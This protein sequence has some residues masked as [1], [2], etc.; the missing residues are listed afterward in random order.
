MKSKLAIQKTATTLCALFIF[1]SG[2]SFAAEK[3][4]N[5]VVTAVE[6]EISASHLEAASKAIKALHASDQFD[7]FLPTASR[8][9]RI[10]LTTKYPNYS[11]IIED[12]VHKEIL[13]L[14]FERGILEK[15]IARVYAKYFSEDELNKI[16]AFYTSPI[17][18]KL[19]NNGPATVSDV[20]DVFRTWSEEIAKKLNENV[21][22]KIEKK[23]AVKSK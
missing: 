19:L 16:T 1:I 8:E 9:L 14:A 22:Q 7:S 23:I 21:S 5:S 18:Q 2:S 10:E 4:K 3:E 13:A 6:P 20:L 15:N 12:T 11:N 17:G